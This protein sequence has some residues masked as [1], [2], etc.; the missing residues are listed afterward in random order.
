[1]ESAEAECSSVQRL[2]GLRRLAR[3]LNGKKTPTRRARREIASGT[4]AEKR[5]R[6]AGSGGRDASCSSV[7][8]AYSW[9]LVLPWL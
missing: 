8:L 1:M 6:R 2:N 7:T 9:A 5:E 4:G 3:C